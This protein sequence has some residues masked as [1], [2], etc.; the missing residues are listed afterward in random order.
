MSHFTSNK[1]I[2]T[3]QN[4]RGKTK[5]LLLECR[6]WH[7]LGAQKIV[8]AAVLVPSGSLSALSQQ[9]DTLFLRPVLG[10]DLLPSFSFASNTEFTFIFFRNSSI[11]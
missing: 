6:V 9:T 8:T 1:I 5:I 3:L 10:R 7:I 2:P 4:C 11:V